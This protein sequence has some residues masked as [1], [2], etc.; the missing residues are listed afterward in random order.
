MKYLIT[1]TWKAENIEKC[2]NLYE[3]RRSSEGTSYGKVLYP[4]SLLV[5]S[6]KGF[7]VMEIDDIEQWYKTNDVWSKLLLFELH[8]ILESETMFKLRK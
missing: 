1:W 2:W 8:P 7:V 4:N 5:G 6:N 3:K